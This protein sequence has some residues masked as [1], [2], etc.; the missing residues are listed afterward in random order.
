MSSLQMV[1][2]VFPYFTFYFYFH[3]ILFSY[4][5]I[6]RT[7][8]Q[9][10]VTRHRE[11]NRRIQNKRCYT[12]Q[13]PHVGLMYYIWLFRVGC[14]VASMDHWQQYIRQISLQRDLYRVLL[15]YS[16]QEL[17][18]CPTLRTLVHNTQVSL[19][20][21]F[22]QIYQLAKLF[23]QLKYSNTTYI[24]KLQDCYY[25]VVSLS[26]YSRHLETNTKILSLFLE[27]LTYF[28][29]KHSLSRY[30]V[31]QFPIILEVGSYI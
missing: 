20:G 26:G 16:I 8:G 17:F 18:Y 5:S 10:Q 25:Y 28:P 2:L 12:I 13:I 11:Q 24:T 22:N 27:H 7:Q 19:F 15:C 9:G 3:F 21:L 30:S 14:T 29:K 23:S 1:D 4:F 6:F 31:N